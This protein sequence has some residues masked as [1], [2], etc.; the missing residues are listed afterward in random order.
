MRLALLAALVGA[1][2]VPVETFNGIGPDGGPDGGGTVNPI[3]A[4]V[5][6]NG[7]SGDKFGSTVA[8]SQDGTTLAVG[9]PGEA[10]AA[11][12]IDGDR[13]DDSAP[14][15]GAVYVFTRSGDEWTLD[16]YLKAASSEANDAFGASIALSDDGSTLAVG[17]PTESTGPNDSGAVYVF[18]RSGAWS[19]E[20]HLKATTV[21]D[22]DRFGTSVALSGDGQTLAAGAPE[23]DAGGAVYVFTR[24]AGTWTPQP[25]V[26]GTN[27]EAGD[28]FGSR[29][30]LSADGGMLAV[31]AVG[32]ASKELHGNG[33]EGD[34]A[35]TPAC[36]AAYVFGRDGGAF[37]QEAYVKA[38]NTGP[39]DFFGRGLALSADG[40]TLAVGATGEGSRA[41]G[42]GGDAT[43]D[44]QPGAGAA[45]VLSRS[46]STWTHVAYVK[47]SNTEAGDQ[48]GISLA[49]ATNGTRLVVGAAFEDGGATG[50]DGDASDN[51]AL[52]AGAAYDYAQSGGWTP[53]RY[54]KA[55]T[56]ERGAQVGTAV[57]MSADGAILVVGA[58]ALAGMK[59]A[60]LV[61]R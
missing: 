55:S 54:L 20:A 17:A 4:V 23:E 14:A 31:S 44:G 22:G 19:Q 35:C 49:L 11:D 56:A 29:T 8:I 34:N 41:T 18:R 38:S 46:G 26:R 42:V 36:G 53:R 47:A 52:N 15:A 2:Y 27:T 28:Q 59:G 48:F 60:V 21:G 10:S 5:A 1:C 50:I 32:E 7:D 61:V 57:A 58:P 51:S 13:E 16:A 45:Y 24:A 3:P 33:G 30:A 40:T 39:G 6:P 43:N 25:I 37:A 12:G 9:A